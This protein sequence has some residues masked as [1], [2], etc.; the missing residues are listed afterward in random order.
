MSSQFIC[1]YVPTTTR[2]RKIITVMY[3]EGNRILCSD[4]V[5]STAIDTI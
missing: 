4:T 5:V 2:S 1:E 3:R